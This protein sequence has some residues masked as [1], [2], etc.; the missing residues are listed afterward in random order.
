MISL[1]R[2]LLPFLVAALPMSTVFAD[3]NN[4][5]TR[6]WLERMNTALRA[7]NY[8]GNFVYIFDNNLGSMRVIHRADNDGGMEHLISLTGTQ[9]EVIR[10]HKEV[11]SI[12][13]SDHSVLIERR[14]MAAHYPVP[15]PQAIHETKLIAFYKFKYL[16]E[17]RVAGHACKIIDIQPRDNYRYG[18]RLWLDNNNGMLLRS[19]L[20]NKNGKIIV[21][22][23]FT[24]ITYP[25]EIPDDAFKATELKPGYIWN[26]QGGRERLI[27]ADAGLNWN[28][29]QL[30]PGFSLSMDNMQRLV[31]TS[32][33][34]R[35]LVYSDGLASVSVFV[36]MA[37]PGRKELIGPS[38][39]EAVS[40]FGRRV[41]NHSI[42]VVGEV[43]P[44]TVEIIAQAMRLQPQ[45]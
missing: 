22:I 37:K 18:Y 36:E 32:S 27:K 13:P 31:G 23:M 6:I 42:T 44:E 17:D 9:R 28:A 41:G 38:Q 20:L 43:P 14:Y 25:H 34:V 10:D 5:D 12:L 45:S 33:P 40:A 4:N 16:G 21:R 2:W 30:P 29:P 3:S 11:M 7:L 39:M 8:E 19:D 15:I 26:I 1:Y 35:H 24:S